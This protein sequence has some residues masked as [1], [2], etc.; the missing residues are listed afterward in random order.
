[1][2]EVARS[3]EGQLPGVGL[4]GRTVVDAVDVRHE[5][6]STGAALVA[7]ER[8]DDVV[9]RKNR[10]TEAGVEDD[11]AVDHGTETG[12][13]GLGHLARESLLARRGQRA[14]VDMSGIEG[15][16]GR[17]SAGRR[18][19]LDEAVDDAPGQLG[20]GSPRLC[21]AQPLL[22]VAG[23]RAARYAVLF[24][25]EVTEGASAVDHGHALA[26]AVRCDDGLDAR[27]QRVVVDRSSRALVRDRRA[28]ELH[29]DK[30]RSNNLL[31]ALGYPEPAA[32]P[33]NRCRRHHHQ[34]SCRRRHEVQV[35]DFSFLLE[36]ME[37]LGVCLAAASKLGRTVVYGD[38]SAAR[39]EIFTFDAGSI[40]SEK[41]RSTLLALQVPFVDHRL[42]FHLGHNYDPAYV[43]LRRM[44]G[45]NLIGD[46]PYDGSSSVDTHGVDPCVVPTLVDAARGLVVVDSRAIVEYLDEENGTL[47]TKDPL[48]AKHVDLVDKFPH[49]RLLYVGARPDLRP[50]YLR[51]EMQPSS[52]G[53]IQLAMIEH[54]RNRAPPDLRPL[55][56]LKAAKT[57]KLWAEFGD[58]ESSFDATR[59]ARR[60][61]ETLNAD[62][63]SFDETKLTAADIAW[64]VTL[65]R[66]QTIGIL[67]VL[68]ADLPN[69]VP[70][71]LRLL[72]SAVLQQG[73]ILPGQPPSPHVTQLLYDH[74][75]LGAAA[76]NVAVLALATLD[77]A[78]RSLYVQV[79]RRP[80]A[81][82]TLATAAALV[83]FRTRRA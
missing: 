33:D 63:P 26:R 12:V 35:K 48:V 24:G 44:A 60:A 54:H 1:M 52:R 22:G 13:E 14:A 83:A 17:E 72:D 49:L 28:T 15:R 2:Y 67:D 16:E 82:A 81:A 9:A 36:G 62:L 8:P 75:G 4:V 5:D 11:V 41:V 68:A 77:G 71:F 69:V 30:S 7:A 40:C 79:A 74:V 78:A 57:R 58:G 64:F 42:S 19:R 32:A 25:L 73:V 3:N 21:D 50:W 27:G 38:A 51:R 56:D 29:D 37:S 31:L 18:A 53:A 45:G 80:V 66:I 70:Y 61:I 65:F 76:A 47:G 39:F 6:S 23:P 46:A 34:Q 59:A 55:Y 20:N 10:I 43:R